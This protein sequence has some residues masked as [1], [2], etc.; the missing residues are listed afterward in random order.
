MHKWITEGEDRVFSFSGEDEER[1]HKFLSYAQPEIFKLAELY[2]A[3]S[4]KRKKIQ[5]LKALQYE[6][7][8]AK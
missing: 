3:S 8:N 2:E 7:Q 1:Y 5:D 4:A 6:Q